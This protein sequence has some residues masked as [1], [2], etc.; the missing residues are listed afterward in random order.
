MDT[1]RAKTLGQQLNQLKE[2][3][4]QVEERANQHEQKLGERNKE[5]EAARQ[6]QKELEQKKNFRQRQEAQINAKRGMLRKALAVKGNE[7]EKKKVEDNR[8]KMIR[9]MVKA[10]DKLKVSLRKQTMMWSSCCK[11]LICKSLG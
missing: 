2:D 3:L 11:K 10:A 8:K 1:E 4:G 9:D 7:D 5:V 6:K